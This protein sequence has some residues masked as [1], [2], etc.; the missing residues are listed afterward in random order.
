MDFGAGAASTESW[1]YYS[2]RDYPNL[3]NAS[4][5]ALLLDSKNS[6]AHYL[7]GIGYEGAGKLREAI[8]EFQKAVEMSAGN[9]DMV[10]ELAHAYSAV[11]RKAEAEKLLRD[12]ERK[13]R[14]TDSTLTMARIYVSL[15]ENDKGFE[16]LEKAYSE[17]SLH[18]PGTLRS[19][20]V[21]DGLRSNPRFQSLLRRMSLPA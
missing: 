8:S 14:G 7:L 1:V 4:K 10:V 20:F 5:R 11:G 16:F 3:I 6:S 9:P 2:L 18:L 15:G 19:D 12:L 21:L 17:K 13:L